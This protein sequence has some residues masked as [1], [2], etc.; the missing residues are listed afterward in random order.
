M[1]AQDI[2][3]AKGFI[4]AEGVFV[5]L[6]SAI[7]SPEVQFLQ[8][9]I[10]QCRPK[11]TLEIGC[12]L[13]IS[14][15]AICDFIGP[16]AHHTIIDP[17][18]STDWNGYGRYNLSQA[19][20]D[21]FELI[22]GR[23]E[24]ELPRLCQQGASFDFVFVDGWHTFD[25]VLM[26]FFYIN[27]M[28]PIGGIVAFDDIALPCLNRLMRYISRYPNYECLGSRG[29]REN[30]SYRRW[31]YALRSFVGWISLPLGNRLR[32]ELLHDGAVRSD[33]SIGLNGTMTA[34]RKTAE[35]G[36]GWAWYEP[37]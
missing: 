11:R 26:E 6:H 29:H 10:G 15:L 35:D 3:E 37:F 13:G 31:L 25:H 4:N 21:N 1:R 28:L 33:A 16:D 2:I 17:F 9:L 24:Y 22:E 19:G 5:D 18:Q 34:F 36:R 12:A 32:G 14:S 30:T 23:S 20:F 7:S 27:R 8:E